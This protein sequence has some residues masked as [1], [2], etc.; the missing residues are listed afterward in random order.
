MPICTWEFLQNLIDNWIA[1]GVDSTEVLSAG[2]IPVILA[3]GKAIATAAPFIAKAAPLIG[4]GIGLLKGKGGK[5]SGGGGGGGQ[6]I[7]GGAGSGVG[8]MDLLEDQRKS[9]DVLGGYGSTQ[10]DRSERVAGKTEDFYSG[11]LGEKAQEK[12]EF[13]A[14]EIAETQSQFDQALAGIESG[15]PRGGERNRALSQAKFG[16]ASSIS[17]ILS[18]ARP[19]GAAGLTKLLEIS[20]NQGIAST[21][22]AAATRGPGLDY[23]SRDRGHDLL[24]R[25]QD[26]AT[27]GKIGKGIGGFIDDFLKDPQ[28]LIGGIGKIFGGGGKSKGTGVPWSG[29]G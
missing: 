27:G 25:E 28:K 6:S 18:G 17:S 9:G 19:A 11:L 12:M 24:R 4:A 1:A 21:A 20:G 2:F 14:P 5:G 15:V 26:L 29:Q 13:F 3:I 7:A 10:L 16:R 22:G 23:W 8:P